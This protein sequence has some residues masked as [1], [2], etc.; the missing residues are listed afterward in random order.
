MGVLS[1]GVAAAYDRVANP[2]MEDYFQWVDG[3]GSDAVVFRLH[4]GRDGFRG[5]RRSDILEEWAKQL[6]PARVEFG[7][8]IEAISDGDGT[9]LVL[10]FRDGTSATADV[11]VG[12]DGI[13]SQIR[14]LVLPKSSAAARANYT[15]KFC[16]RALVPMERA[17]AAIGSYRA[18]T[19]FMYNGPGAHVITYPVGNNTVLNVLAVLSDAEAWSPPA[20]SGGEQSKRHTASGNKQEAVA[21]FAGWHG[22]V[23]RIV[24]LLPDEM[25]K[26]AVFDM[27]EHPAP[28]YVRD[29]VCV[30]GDA[31]HAAGPHLGAGG[32]MGIED[33]LVLSELLAAVDR[34]L[35]AGGTGTV[36]EP[37][38]VLVKAALATYNDARY[39]RTQDVVQSTRAACDLFQWQNPAVG[40][41]G[42]KFG[43][44]ITKRFYK[45]WNYDVEAMV[46]DALVQFGVR[47]DQD[48]T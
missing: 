12:C 34:R 46:Q 7:K 4:V 24:D 33:A 26:W 36:A 44:E 31:A 39:E 13:H 29:C 23:R 40:S 28:T 1:G 42:A 10:R 14:Q 15:H 43:H 32:G 37:K 45:V 17:V 8:E 30:A 35:A 6:P 3:H 9:P 27:A 25:D 18:G 22:T 41:D 19:R 48:R 21:A 11:V 5:C 20:E 47:V 2:N 16:F 38:T